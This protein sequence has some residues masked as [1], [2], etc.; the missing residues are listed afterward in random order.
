MLYGYEIDG[1]SV[2]AVIVSSRSGITTAVF[3]VV[4]VAAI[5]GTNQLGG[6]KHVSPINGHLG[7]LHRIVYVYYRIYDKNKQF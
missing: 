2:D 3:A 7:E 6:D 5:A 1:A 4:F